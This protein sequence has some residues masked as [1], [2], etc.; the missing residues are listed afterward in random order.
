MVCGAA[1][2]N[3]LIAVNSDDEYYAT[4]LPIA[5]IRYCYLDPG[6]LA[7]RY[8]PDY[9]FLGITVS[10]AQFEDLGRWEPQFRERLLGWGLPSGAPIATNIMAGSVEDI[11]RLVAN[12]PHSD[13]Y[14]QASIVDQIPPE[15]RSAR[16]IVRL[17]AD[18][19]FLLAADGQQTAALHVPWRMPQ[20]W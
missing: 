18:R 10:T 9:A 4:A 1:A 17:S 7:R 13:F 14:L 16:R 11:V 5:K 12:H 6:Q 20:D 8:A 19:C 2:A 15:V 3:E